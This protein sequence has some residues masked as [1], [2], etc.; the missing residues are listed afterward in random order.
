MAITQEMFRF[1]TTRRPERAIMSRIASKLMRD[2]REATAASLLVK[3]F[4][5]GLYETE[6]VTAN[7]FAA[8]ADFLAADSIEILALEPA[9][10]FFRAELATDVVLS[11]L[12]TRMEAQLPH[13][14]AL[15]KNAPPANL[16]EATNVI[17]GRLWDSLYAQ[18]I[19]GCDR[20]VSTNYLIDGLRVYHVLGLLWLSR[21]LGLT[22]WTGGA[23]DDYEALIDLNRALAVGGSG[24]LPAGP[25]AH[26]VPHEFGSLQT[27]TSQLTHI[28]QANSAIETLLDAGL[29]RIAPDD[30]PKYFDAE[31]IRLLVKQPALEKIDLEKTSVDQLVLR[32][33]KKRSLVS[34]QRQDAL[35]ALGDPEGA[36][37]YHML[38]SRSLALR[39]AAQVEAAS[40]TNLATAGGVF[41]VPLSVGAIK[42]PTVG[43]LILVEQELN[44]YELGELADIESIMRGERR[45]RTIRTLARTTQTTTTESSL[46]EEQSSSLKTDERF[47]LSSEAQK[48]ASESFGVQM[49]VSVSGK[50]GPVQVGATVNASYDTSKSTSESTSQEYAKT[51]TEEA[52]K[53]VKSSIKETSSI[54]IL[55]ETQNTSLRGFNNEKGSDHVNGLYRWV[56]KIYTARLLNYGRRLMFSLA[57][58]EP[59]A[60]YRSLLWQ[61]EAALMEGLVEPL[62]PSRIGR[63]L[64]DP[65]PDTNTTGGFL[66]SRDITEDNYALLAAL[67]DVSVQP[68]PPE[69]LTGSKAIVYPEAMQASTIKEHDDV[70]GSN[71]SDLNYVAADNTLT[72]DPNYR[73]TSVAVFAS[74]GAAGNLSSYVDA[75]KLGEDGSKV[76]DANL[77]L[78]QVAGKDFYLSAYKNP[79]G[80]DKKEKI[81]T[82]N[83]N[84]FE[85]I[86]EDWHAFGE[87]VQ[88]AIPITIVANFEG[89]LTFTVIYKA[90]R[91]DE[92][93]DAWKA[94]TFAAIVKGYTTKKQAYDQAVAL[95]NAKAQTGTEAQNF[96]LREDQ[97]RSIELTELQ[98]GCI[99][100]LTEGTAAGYTS[101]AVA[102]DGTPDIVYDAAEGNLLGNWRSPLANGSVAEFFQLA[103]EWESTVYQFHPYFW[104]GAERWKDLAQAS[105][106]DPIFEQFLRA[107]SA[108]VVV[109]VRPGYER[110]VILFL[111]T[112]LIWGGGK[113]ALFTSQDML[114]VYADVELGLQLDPPEQIGD[115]WEI[116]LPTS[117]VMLQEDEILPT[118]PTT[119]SE[120][121]TAEATELVMDETVPF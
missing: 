97:Y 32:L 96:Q 44:R 12:A 81:I 117:L 80:S 109:P 23:F 76:E 7:T 91:L 68:P 106:A 71:K 34:T 29:V 90:Y 38:A 111:K 78:V 11:D 46:E 114:D 2:R 84:T 42:P 98:R 102:E 17:V 100:L 47:S 50:F 9:M 101:I 13:L 35:A 14:T 61:N 88:G 20:Y 60:F 99:D 45:E 4:G 10:V 89:M 65:L 49:G 56:D 27:L 108:S 119:T 57:V 86:D 113:L 19:R 95:A 1:V 115:S 73:I 51:V 121:D 62:H 85:P 63:G 120:D 103:F 16:L 94:Q 116:R 75:L 24:E 52:T 87:K 66:S 70:G 107:G 3:L 79:D 92:A 36:A 8:S 5:P 58:P 41:R 112:G 105:G 39:S 18:T 104:A 83:F 33:E 77:V 43:D 15:L 25:I 48:T 67:Y 40:M 59:A 118:F 55:T 26:P 74:A 82:T 93:F 54:T 37:E 64:V 53:R 22:T 31:A 72:V 69:Y 21:K 110:P 28:D 6:L 30:G